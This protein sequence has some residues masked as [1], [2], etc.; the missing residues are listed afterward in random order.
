MKTESR[1]W[2]V[3]EM[4]GKLVWLEIGELAQSGQ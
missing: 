4:I 1:I 2:H 3:G